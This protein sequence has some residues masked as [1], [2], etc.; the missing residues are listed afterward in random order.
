MTPFRRIKALVDTSAWILIAP[1]LIALFYID[2]S[3]LA[4]LVQW[5]VF[6]PVLAGVAV[7]VSR[8]VFPQ[9]HLSEL[10][11]ETMKGNQAAA[12]LAA[13]LVVFVALLVLSLV[14]W[15]RA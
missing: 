7:I 12:T 14:F 5:L 10:V 8:I 13:A 6:A 3:M 15:A 9:I 1:S 2:K 11:R 4:T